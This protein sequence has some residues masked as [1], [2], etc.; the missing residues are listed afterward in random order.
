MKTF[1]QQRPKPVPHSRDDRPFHIPVRKIDDKKL[2]VIGEKISSE[3]PTTLALYKALL[4]LKTVA[5][6]RT[7]QITTL[8][9][10]LQ[11]ALANPASDARA[12]GY[13]ALTNPGMLDK[14]TKKAVPQHWLATLVKL[15]ALQYRLARKRLDSLTKDERADQYDSLQDIQRKVIDFIASVALS[16]AD[17]VVRLYAQYTLARI[18]P[19]NIVAHESDRK[20]YLALL[21]KIGTADQLLG[22]IR[23]PVQQ[24]STLAL[25]AQHLVDLIEEGASS[26]RERAIFLLIR[27]VLYHGTLSEDPYLAA[28]SRL[29]DDGVLTEKTVRAIILEVRAS[30]VLQLFGRDPKDTLIQGKT[31]SSPASIMTIAIESRI[32]PLV[33]RWARD[34]DSM[35]DRGHKARAVFAYARY[36]SDLTIIADLAEKIAKQCETPDTT[37]PRRVYPLFALHEMLLNP[38]VTEDIKSSIRERL[39]KHSQYVYNAHTA[40]VAVLRRIN[41]DSR[42]HTAVDSEIM[43]LLC[44]KSHGLSDTLKKLYDGS[45]EEYAQLILIDLYGWLDRHQIHRILESTASDRVFRSAMAELSTVTRD[46]FHDYLY[47]LAKHAQRTG[48]EVGVAALNRALPAEEHVGTR[49]GTLSH[50]LSHTKDLPPWFITTIREH[51]AAIDKKDAVTHALTSAWYILHLPENAKAQVAAIKSKLKDPIVFKALYAFLESFSGNAK[52]LRTSLAALT[53]DQDVRTLLVRFQAAGEIDR[54]G[55]H[56]KFGAELTTL[57]D[58]HSPRNAGAVFSA[59]LRGK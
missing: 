52:D 39:V 49:L 50:L 29:L 22:R 24:S 42:E 26:T 5:S 6:E 40:Y 30:K 45:K 56:K 19:R 16:A 8:E 53:D 43:S 38:R 33:C 27:Q 17:K 12:L 57:L 3:T 11:E 32:S 9:R 51:V 20:E 25:S 2:P 1:A 44:L 37:N 23:V 59:A 34:P 15:R 31:K 21:E 18:S 36:G 14:M 47:L 58:S 46:M 35:F 55:H 54:F 41:D 7:D 48:E 10:K 28:G 4:A 13:F